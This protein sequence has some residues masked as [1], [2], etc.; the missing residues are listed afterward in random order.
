M[1]HSQTYTL[2]LV[3]IIYQLYTLANACIIQAKRQLYLVCSI[4][5]TGHTVIQEVDFYIH[6][7]VEF[8]LV[9]VMCVSLLFQATAHYAIQN[10]T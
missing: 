9:S 6:S 7:C 5:Q 8:V 1:V 4:Y 2:N 10:S 3:H